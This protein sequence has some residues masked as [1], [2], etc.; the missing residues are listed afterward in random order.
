MSSPIVIRPD[1]VDRPLAAKT[2]NE[3]NL[4]ARE[5][6][7]MAKKEKARARRYEKGPSQGAY[8]QL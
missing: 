8:V 1:D 5:K 6:R 3:G 4:Q 2:K 7:N